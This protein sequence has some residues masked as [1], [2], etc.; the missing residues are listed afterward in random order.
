MPVVKAVGRNSCALWRSESKPRA[1]RGVSLFSGAEPGG[2]GFHFP[3]PF[4]VGDK[5]SPESEP[6]L[7]VNKGDKIAQ[8]FAK[9]DE[10]AILFAM[11]T[12]AVFAGA[13]GMKI[14]VNLG[15]RHTELQNGA[16]PGGGP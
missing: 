10:N 3:Q 14:G 2:A 1:L 9:G 4:T 8:V 16:D 12:W 5:C 6:V 11:S 13:H 15:F 7:G